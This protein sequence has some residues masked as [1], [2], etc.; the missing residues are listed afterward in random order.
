MGE[1]REEPSLLRQVREAAFYT[2]A[3][4]Q[5]TFNRVPRAS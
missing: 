2:R 5:P 4:V 1:P 3:Q